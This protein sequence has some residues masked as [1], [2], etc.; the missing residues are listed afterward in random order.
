MRTLPL[1]EKRSPR[2]ASFN[3]FRFLV[4]LEKIVHRLDWRFSLVNQGVNF[5]NDRRIDVQLSCAFVSAFCRGNPFRDHLH[6]RSNLPDRLPTPEIFANPSITAVL[7]KTGRNQIAN[8][9]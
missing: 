3:L 4:A 7:A 2:Q 9:A 6:R 5:V 8:A 1:S